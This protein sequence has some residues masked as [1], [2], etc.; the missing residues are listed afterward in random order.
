[1]GVVLEAHDTKLDRRV[2]LK[3]LPSEFVADPARLL[4][5]QR[6]A[7][8]LAALN[9]PNI[10]TIYD[11]AEF[12][13]LHFLIMELVQGTSLKRM[14]PR[15][16]LTL[17]AFLTTATA[18]TDALDAAT[19]Q[20]ITHRDLK[21]DNI[22]VTPSGLVKVLDFGLAKAAEGIGDHATE[23]PASSH[24]TQDGCLVGTMPYMSPE[25]VQGL[26]VDHRSDIFSLGVVL[27]EMLTGRRPFG[28]DSVA[29]LISAILRDSPASV[30][31]LRRDLH[32]QVDHIVSTCLAKEPELRFQTAAEVHRELQMLQRSVEVEKALEQGVPRRRILGAGVRQLG[33]AR[34]QPHI[35][36]GT[37]LGL[38]CVLAVLF[39]CN[40]VE[41]TAES[42]LART[43]GLGTE[44][45]Q[46]LAAAAHWL[47]GSYRFVN[48]DT[49]NLLCVY[50]SS[51]AYFFVFP[52]LTLLVGLALALRQ[53]IVP[54]RTFVLAISAS[55]LVALPFF[56]FFPVVE[57]WAFPASG[58]VLLSDLWS[59]RLIEVARPISGIDNCFPSFHVSL[60]LI[61]VMLSFVYRINQR[62]VVLSL[63]IPIILST[64]ILGI[65]WLTDIVAGTAVA[66]I[67]V[68][69][70][71]RLQRPY[72]SEQPPYER[73]QTPSASPTA[74]LL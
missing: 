47:E 69:V 43:T 15:D 66:I 49:V 50:A 58:A 8:T 18:L 38:T 17:D 71:V 42:H 31:D 34:S 2:A 48:H 3:I 65:H 40:Y 73:A 36:L 27:Y 52:L 56:L 5:F 59:S 21:P 26:A 53:S 14:I 20:G 7:R 45:G 10:V 23:H 57:R 24:L 41:T 74:G 4:R 33:I 63:G 39:A 67:S 13:G 32:P 12:E 72:V 46:T 6:E 30:I 70:A 60:T 22:M 62:W 55:Y 11:V 35:I 25:Q 51:C 19:R 61:V 1:M 29:Q 54:L 28:G 68:A 16:G 64:W 37:R 44:L 9:H